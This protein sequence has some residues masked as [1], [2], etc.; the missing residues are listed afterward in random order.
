MQNFS[1]EFI[2]DIN[3]ESLYREYVYPISIPIFAIFY[4]IV[5][6]ALIKNKNIAPLNSAYFT[7]FIH[8]GYNTF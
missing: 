4:G 1:N 7:I 6:I 2:S 3:R 8:A 5:L